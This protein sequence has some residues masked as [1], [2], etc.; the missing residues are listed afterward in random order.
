MHALFQ[1]LRYALRQLGKSPGFTLTAVLT[2]ALGIGVNTAVFSVVNAVLLRPLPYASPERLISAEEA[3]TQSPTGRTPLSYPD[4]FDWRAQNHTL[5]QLVCYYDNELALTGVSRPE[6]VVAEVV[7]WNLLPALGVAPEFGRG[8]LPEEE[9]PGA[10]VVLL[11]H[12]LWMNQ[13][14]GDRG[15]VG[16]TISLSGNLYTVVGV[17]PASFRFP[18]QNPHVALWT[19]LATDATAKDP[20]TAQRGAHL[21]RTIGRL[22]PGVSAQQ[23]QQDLSLIAKNLQRQYPESNTRQDSA[24]VRSESET[25]VGD[26]RTPLLILLGAVFLVLLIAC[27]NLANLLLARTSQRE[28]EIAVRSAVGASRK[29]IV[30]Q[31]LTESVLLSAIGGIAGCL[32]AVFCTRAMLNIVGDSIP[33]AAQA[34]VDGPVLAFAALVTL[35]TG[36]LFGVVPAFK[37]S[38]TDLLTN[39]KQSGRADVGHRDWLRNAL[40]IA[41]IALGLILST[42][43]GLLIASFLYL[44]HSGMGFTPDHVLT[45]SFD[46]PDNQ[47]PDLKKIEFYRDYFERVRQLPGVQAAAGSMVFPLGPNNFSI[48]FDNQDHP[49]PKGQRSGSPASV[50]T[51]D[52][53]KT[54]QIPLLAGRDF[55]ER[56]DKKAQ[57]VVIVSEAFARKYFPGENAI[58]KHIQPGASDLDNVEP[59]REIIGI[60]G[61]T[62]EKASGTIDQPMYYMPAAQLPS[63][64]CLYTIARTATDPASMEPSIRNL[65]SV[66][67]KDLP[68]YDVRTMDDLMSVGLAQPRFHMALLGS[69]AA[70]ALLL[71]M[72]GLYGVMTYSVTRRTREIGV[73]MALGAA[74]SSVLK[75]VLREAGVM[76]AIGLAIGITG[77]LL[78]GAVLRSL[79]YGTTAHNPRVL[80]AV[81]MILCF[82]G[83][84]AAFIPAH[85]AA[86]IE[87]MNALRNE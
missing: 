13:F 49:M 82:T 67:N 85:R 44:Q 50:I 27:A 4:F 71:T 34:G 80:I 10:R 3:N 59:W 42:A 77:A 70:I 76:V 17:M 55:T 16:R 65:V 63:W 60:V 83:L 86:S 43:A 14:G 32:L 25:V 26:N 58:G 46:L 51:P 74:R 79:L 53:F 75:M 21:L 29:R 24:R 84:I 48:S 38:K 18:V 15:I 19:T 9:K 23:A 61:N 31:L 68:I 72:I 52:Y 62:K 37:A 36:L 81:C 7:S 28:R 73:R 1:D 39:L 8:F 45:L 54:L 30:C 2:L 33:R 87:P 64:C 57:A 78:A 12:E 6:Q 22:K 47:Y 20:M 11:S 66:M 40:V 56:D 41:Q 35:G 69:F 5:E